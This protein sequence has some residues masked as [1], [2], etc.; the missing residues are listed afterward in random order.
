VYEHP[1]DDTLEHT[2]AN[3]YKHGNK[4]TDYSAYQLPNA[5]SDGRG[6]SI[7]NHNGR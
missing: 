7:T 3:P 4:H 2:V 6:G 1:N 5:G